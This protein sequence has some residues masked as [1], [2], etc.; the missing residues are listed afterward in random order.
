[1][2]PIKN[3][4]SD[5][6]LSNSPWEG[7]ATLLA[8]RIRELLPERKGLKFFMLIDGA[9]WTGKSSLLNLL[10]FK[11]EPEC[12]T[13]KLE[14][15]REERPGRRPI[16]AL[17]RA[18][19]Q[20]L[21]DQLQ[22][23]AR[24]KMRIA[25]AR[26]WLRDAGT[27][28]FVAVFLLVVLALVVFFLLRPDNLTIKTVRSAAE[29]ITAL[30]SAVGIICGGAIVAARLLVSGS[31]K[32][33]Q[34][35]QE[36]EQS[37]STQVETLDARF[38]SL[39]KIIKRPLMFLI[40]DLERCKPPYV[41][42]LLD[43]LKTLI[44]EA[45]RITDEPEPPVVVVVAGDARWIRHCFEE[46]Y[47]GSKYGIAP[48][49]PREYVLMEELFDLTIPMPSPSYASQVEYLE[50]LVDESGLEPETEKLKE[51]L[52]ASITEAELLETFHQAHAHLR[53][54]FADTAVVKLTTPEVK[55]AV[56]HSLKQ[57]ASLLPPGPRGLKRFVETYVIARTLRFLEGSDL[58]SGTLALWTIL[59]LRWPALA[60]FLQ[61]LPEMVE[62][63][64]SIPDDLP[65]SIPGQLRCLF[66]DPRVERVVHFPQGGPLTPALIRA[67]AQVRNK[68]T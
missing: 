65:D 26:I 34:F 43:A 31:S 21:R 9:E 7:F 32:K 50:Q 1:M 4:V 6:P 35:N 67:C 54:V 14:G 68:A 11:L 8:M 19:R 46:A 20:A 17:L 15:R 33:P 51:K 22:W 30:A 64:G 60:D 37:S 38:R 57:F 62:F 16:M 47:I 48:G 12:L 24:A 13:V 5:S 23:S 36:S 18:F 28:Y 41:V 58:A 27:P 49:R 3:I 39:R 53:P 40:D 63:V 2:N 56:E 29:T 44:R 61:E 55:M 45:P 66:F 59:R 10:R 52:T 42:E 25:E